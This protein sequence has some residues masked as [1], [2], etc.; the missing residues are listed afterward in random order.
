MLTDRTERFLAAELI[1]E[2][3]FLALAPGGAV[4]GRR[5]HRGLGGARRQGDVV[6]AA[7]IV[8]ERDSQR[9][10]V[11]GKGGAMIRDVGTAARG[12]D[13]RARCS[14]PRTSSCT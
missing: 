3:L 7:T 11:L 12:G 10:I 1:R 8:V 6:I 9:A 4:R 13:Q 5:R 14:A 2:Q